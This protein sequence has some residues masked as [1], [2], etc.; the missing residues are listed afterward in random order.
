MNTERFNTTRRDFLRVGATSLGGL[1]VS[2]W[3]PHSDANSK[4]SDEPA[5][6]RDGAQLFVRVEPN[7]QVFIGARGP[8]IGQ[9][10]RTSLP[11]LIAEE[12]DVSWAQVSVEQLPYG[13]EAQFGAQWVGGS[14]NIP[15]SWLEL[16]QVGARVRY[17]FLQAAA[18]QWNIGVGTLKTRAGMVLHPDGSSLSYGSLTKA[19]QQMSGSPNPLPLKTKDQ[20]RMIG[21]DTPVT[22]AEAIVTGQAQYGMDGFIEGSLTAVIE[23]CPYLD[24]EIESP[25]LIGATVRVKVYMSHAIVQP[26]RCGVGVYDVNQVSICV[27]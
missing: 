11:M 12:L 14:T 1:M 8:E 3:L 21:H 26:C 4:S 15:Q 7:D 23:R 6:L 18:Q 22:D 5:W 13:N 20:F 16:R 24:G 2:G 25:R 17:L 9:G 27:V 10:V 19:A